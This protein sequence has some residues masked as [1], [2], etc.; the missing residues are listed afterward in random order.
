M[1]REPRWS[2]T[3]PRPPL[4]THATTAPSALLWSLHVPLAPRLFRHSFSTGCGRKEAAPVGQQQGQEKGWGSRD[5]RRRGVLLPPS[6]ARAA[7]F[8]R[9]FNA[10]GALSGWHATGMGAPGPAAKRGARCQSLQDGK[11]RVS[12]HV[13]AGP[14]ARLRDDGRGLEPAPRVRC[15]SFAQRRR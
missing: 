14:G 4:H 11:D 6:A 15:H 9:F 5:S 3:D 7:A 1:C 12:V 8:A 13:R 2:I 10:P